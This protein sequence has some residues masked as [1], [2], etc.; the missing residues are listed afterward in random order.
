M[1][2]SQVEGWTLDVIDR[3]MTGRP[4]E[5][6]RVELKADWP[7][8]PP[9][10]ARRIAGHLNAARGE[11]VLWIIGADEGSRTTPGASATDSATWW[12][13]VAR[14]FD[15]LPPDPVFLNV[16]TGSTTVVAVFLSSERAPLV[17]KSS[18]GG[19]PE[20][21]VP[22]RTATRVRSAKRSELMR[23]LVPATR[24][25][26]I[27]VR[28]ATLWL[29]QAGEQTGR[30]EADRVRHQFSL[31]IEAYL[32]PTSSEVLVLPEHR[33]S[34]EILRRDGVELAQ[35]TLRLQP[36]GMPNSFYQPE[37]YSQ[38][39]YPRSTPVIETISQGAS[40]LIVQGPGLLRLTAHENSSQPW[41]LEPNEPYDVRVRLGVVAAPGTATFSARL[42]P[43]PSS[44]HNDATWG[45]IGTE[46]TYLNDEDDE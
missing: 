23:V 5:D 46:D 6:D 12:D 33:A 37:F 30:A 25:P 43:V 18:S 42:V 31:R 9:K 26:E 36:G 32:E 22:W 7:Q 40:Q 38:R 3:L 41:P 28:E 13:M 35:P 16:P 21:E 34:L 27:E 4:I 1:R 10:A 11:P 44:R 29:H 8:D 19:S 45:L 24:L 39:G 15:E 2:H 17:V 20:R 14:W